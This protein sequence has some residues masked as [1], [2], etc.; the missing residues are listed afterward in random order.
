MVT[1]SKG[2]IGKR[3]LNALIDL[4]T[5]AKGLDEDYFRDDDWER[6]LVT[7]LNRCNP[8]IIFHV[9]ACSNTL[10]TN[11][12]LMMEQN[13]QSTKIMSEWCRVN[14]RKLIYSSSAANYG[15]NGSYPSNLYGWSKYVAEDFVLQ[16]N[17]V[18]LR[19]FN[20]YGPGEEHK[21][22]M[23]SFVHQAFLSKKSGNEVKLFPDRPKR[24]FVYVD[25]VV[26]AN[27]F[28]AAHF[29]DLCG[30][31]YEVST[32]VARTFEEVL[33]IAEIPFNYTTLDMVPNG[34]QYFTCGDSKK[35]MPGWKPRYTI[36]LGMSRYLTYLNERYKD[37]D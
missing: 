35:W 6:H 18:A 25:D 2:F 21:G 24:D 13:Y 27:I 23:S 4:G 37:E 36:E 15:V 17:G 33:S 22:I 19:Y 5:E 9:G 12:H 20:V 29:L 3:L 10:E 11:V 31:Y 7:T 1:G 8:E 16:N 26:E 32:G 14:D 34:Y 28:A 30:R